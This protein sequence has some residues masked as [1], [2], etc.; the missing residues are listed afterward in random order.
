[1]IKNEERRKERKSERE[2][3]NRALRARGHGVS[4]KQVKTVTKRNKKSFDKQSM[5]KAVDRNR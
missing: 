4:S 5:D 3:R 2:A 1:M